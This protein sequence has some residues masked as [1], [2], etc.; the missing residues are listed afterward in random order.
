[1][2]LLA[3]GLNVPDDLLYYADGTVLVGEHGDGHLAR[4]GP[5]GVLRLPQTIPE[6]EGM[7]EIAG[8]TY[9]A[10]QF[11]AR[12]VAL[13][14]SSVRTVLQLQPVASGE[15]LDGISLDLNG[16]GLVV[17]D[18]PH[19]T[20][21][22]VNTS[23]S[24]TGRVAGFSRPA[25]SWPDPYLGGYLIADE[26][27]GVVYELKGGATQRIASGLPLVD[28]VV[29]DSRSHVLVTL[30]AQGR[31]YD[32][33]AGTSL[34]SGLKNPQGL[35]FDGAQNLLVTESDAGRLDLVVTSFAVSTPSKTVQLAPGQGVCYGILRAPGNTDS[36]R[37]FQSIGAVPLDDPQLGSEGEVVPQ[38]C[39]LPL[40]TVQLVIQ[41][42]TGLEFSSFTYRD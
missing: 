8:V 1:M 39:T 24:V 42:P 25:G 12:V 17:P 28:D 23:G 22:F 13:T 18:S 36:L 41:G 19:G 3:S 16:T 38:P 20:V 35:G 30:P 15:N 34:V 4:I 10:D 11:D 31:L 37:V 33:T 5:A 7:A 9:I 40:C 29:R 27:A 26:G 21:L 2:L 32:V 6:P 14:D